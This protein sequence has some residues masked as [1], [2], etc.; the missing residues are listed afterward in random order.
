M[1]MMRA[2]QH[3][4]L[5]VW[6]GRLQVLSDVRWNDGVEGARNDEGWLCNPR[7]LWRQPR[8]I[9]LN[10]ACFTNR[11]QLGTEHS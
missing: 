9:F 4:S 10:V 1:C 11:Q 2:R 8:K 7:Q 5:R 3:D 6:K